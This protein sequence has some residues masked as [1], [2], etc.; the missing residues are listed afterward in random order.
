VYAVLPGTL[1][2]DRL[3]QILDSLGHVLMARNG[4][5]LVIA[6]PPEVAH[7]IDMADPRDLF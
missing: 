3:D 2:P 4:R 1:A 6:A 7:R 5:A